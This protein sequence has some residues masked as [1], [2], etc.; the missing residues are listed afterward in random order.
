M[1]IQ[2]L[3]CFHDEI[4]QE[5]L[6]AREALALFDIRGG[7]RVISGWQRQYHALD[8]VGL[9]PNPGGNSKNP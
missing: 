6:S 7:T 4:A 5:R 1:P 9:Q 2:P 8:L 3:G